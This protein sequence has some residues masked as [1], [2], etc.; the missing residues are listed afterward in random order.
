MK[1]ALKLSPFFCFFLVPE[2]SMTTVAWI[3]C[4]FFNSGNYRGSDRI[5]RVRKKLKKDP[6][7]AKAIQRRT[8]TTQGRSP[9]ALLPAPMK[10]WK[11]MWLLSAVAMWA[12][13][14]FLSLIT[15]VIKPPPP[16]SPMSN[17]TNSKQ[18]ER[19]WRGGTRWQ[20]TAGQRRVIMILLSNTVSLVG[21]LSA[22]LMTGLGNYRSRG[23]FALRGA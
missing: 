21:C 15:V 13:S 17:Y 19:T 14:L 12:L 1:P 9:S 5:P 23:R 16:S 2:F 18:K 4:R 10:T 11:R 20:N 3:T 22:R 8:G 7:P 6:A